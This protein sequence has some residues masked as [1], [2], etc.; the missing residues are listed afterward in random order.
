MVQSLRGANVVLVA[1]RDKTGRTWAENWL[2]ELSGVARSV[3]LVASATLGEKDDAVEHI[4]AGY[5]LDD[6]I[7][8][9][10]EDLVAAAATDKTREPRDVFSTMPPLDPREPVEPWFNEWRTRHLAA[11]LEEARSGHA[12]L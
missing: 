11:A 8:V 3:K 7:S 5:S 1:D 12:T 10:P 9:S 2:G 6:L 4:E